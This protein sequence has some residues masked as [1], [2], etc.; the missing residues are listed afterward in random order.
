VEDFV[1][2]WPDDITIAVGDTVRWVNGPGGSFHDVTADDYSWASPVGRGWVYE[3][4][5]N[6]AGEFRYHCE[7]HDPNDADGTHRGIVRVTQAEGF[8]I[9]PG[10]N[11]AWYNPDT[12]G[13]G[14]FINVF[15]NIG[16]VFL[17]W[18]TYDTERPDESVSAILGDPGHR[19]L[20][21]FGAYAGDHAVLDI[22]V[23][24]GGVFDAA[25]PEPAQDIDGTI[26]LEFSSC[27]SGSVTYNI[28]SIGRQGIIPIERIA[29]DNVPACEASAGLAGDKPTAAI[30]TAPKTGNSPET[31]GFQINR[32]LNDAWYNPATAGQGF[33]MNVFPDIGQ[34][35]L[36]WF[37]YDAERPDESVAANL[38]DPGHRWITA[39]GPYTGSEAVLGVEITEGGVFDAASPQPTQHTDGTV[40]VNM[41]DC[42]NGTI[43]YDITSANL[44]G[45][46]PIERIALDN[47]PVCQSLDGLPQQ[48]PQ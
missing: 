14:F 8:P 18:F 33:F 48:D 45:E 10:L 39:F 32:G 34:M 20:T 2:Y 7:F 23:T 11:D 19:W 36:A 12:P 41:S 26:T 17:A 3:H 44:K 30:M 25:E 16:Q 15:P 5:F 35:F 38:G 27:N 29:L 43:T 13:Q 46:I 6:T 40:T 24:Q 37:T 1:V 4:T 9:N 22:E 42:E 47:V 28:P 21:A 31:G